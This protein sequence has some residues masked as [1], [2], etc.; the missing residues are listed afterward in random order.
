MY[1]ARLPGYSNDETIAEERQFFDGLLQAKEKH[2]L[3]GRYALRDWHLVRRSLRELLTAPALIEN[4]VN[5]T[6]AKSL[7]LWRSKLFEKFPGDDALDWHQEYGYFDG[8][9]I[10]GHRPALYPM[11]HESPWTWTVWL[12]FTDVGPGDGVMEFVLGSHLRTYSKRM[13]PLPQSG[14]FAYLDP[15]KRARTK[16]ELIQQVEEN[17]PYS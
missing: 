11:G 13:V 12:P 16:T 1:L 10:G 9:E 4:I 2:P 5:A 15:V 3:Y 6:G 14:A 8:E 17:S 7:M